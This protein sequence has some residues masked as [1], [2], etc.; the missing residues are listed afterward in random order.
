MQPIVLDFDGSLGPIPGAQ[1]LELAPWQEAVRYGCSADTL[2]RLGRELAS[3]LPPAHGPVFMGSGDFH[4]VSLPLI[5]RLT[6]DGPLDV[7]VFDNHPDNMRFPWGVHCG[8]WVRH[9]AKLPFVRHVRVMGISSPDVALWHAWENTLGPLWR[10]R[11]S[12]W[13][14]GDHARW[15]AHVGL[16]DAMR[17]FETPAAML[18]EFAGEQRD[19]QSRVYLSIDKDVLDPGVARTN[20]DQGR[21]GEAD[22]YAAIGALRGRLT[23]C[24]VT[25]EVSIHSYATRW[26]RWLSALDRQPPIDPTQLAAW[27]AQ[28][29]ALNLRLLERLGA[30]R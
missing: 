4:H 11:V 12:Y 30:I 15:G 21:L 24:D 14:L 23:G 28:Q 10:G 29:H 19:A 3:R 9:V 17:C 1:V 18:D 5:A 22:L 7:V 27:Q 16:G 6:S 20:W 26:K 25:G 2:A 8:S 13:C